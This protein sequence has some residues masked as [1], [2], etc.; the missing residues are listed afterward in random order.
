V[1]SLTRFPQYQHVM[2][3][4]FVKAWVA[5]VVVH[6]IIQVALE[7]LTLRDNQQAKG[8]TDLCLSLMQVPTG[9]PL[10]DRNGLSMCDGIPGHDDVTCI[11]IDSARPQ[12][13]PDGVRTRALSDFDL[14]GVN[15]I[16]L[17]G[18]EHLIT[19]RCALALHWIHNMWVIAQ[20]S[21]YAV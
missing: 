8:V 12:L 17:S 7:G 16:T 15:T 3:S 9:L 20:F 13:P 19:G 4:N 14:D 10:L 21:S 5:L 18:T 6:F 11:L 1:I 2:A